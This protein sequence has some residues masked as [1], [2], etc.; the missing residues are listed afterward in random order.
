[1]IAGPHV[2]DVHQHLG[3]VSEVLSLPDHAPGGTSKERV[4]DELERRLDRMSA[5]SIDQA[6]IL[7]PPGYLRPDGVRDTARVNDRVAAYRAAQPDRFVAAVGVAEPLYG[8]TS[9]PELDRIKGELGMAQ[10]SFH[11]RFQGC[12]TDNPLVM[13][14]VGRMGELGTG[15]FR[16]CLGRGGR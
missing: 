2:I 9:L 15:A 4:A 16:A 14:I 7:A 3:D 12:A 13:R 11:T 5:D 10:V 8:A 6:V 1:V